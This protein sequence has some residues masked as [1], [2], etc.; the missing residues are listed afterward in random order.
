MKCDLL[1]KGGTVVDPAN[2]LHGTMDVAVGEGRIVAIASQLPHAAAGRVV[3]VRGSIVTAGLVDLHTHCYWGATYWGIDPDPVAARTGVTTWVDAGSAGAFN[4]PGFRR[5]VFEASTA[6]TFAFLN[7]STIGL[8]APT[9]ELANLAYCDVV[10]GATIVEANRDCI[11]GIKV[12]VDRWTTGEAG[13][14]GLRRART[15]A[16]Q[17]GLP[18]MVHIGTAPP[19]LQEISAFLRTGDILT[20]CFTGQ[21]NRLVDAAGAALSAALRLRERGVLLDTGHGS[22]SFSFGSAEAL[23][24]AGI[25]PDV[26]SSDMHQL[27][28]IGHMRDLPTTL[29]KFLALGMRLDEVIAC[30]TIRPAMAIGRDDLGTLGVGARAD[31]AVF[32]IEEGSFEFY[33][34]TSAER[35][36]SVRLVNTA[37]FVGGHEF[38]QLQEPAPAPWAVRDLGSTQPGLRGP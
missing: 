35:R 37:T 26:I 5:Y 18:L 7:I 19:T 4:F 16:D 27:S 33:D 1:L 23:L 31:I 14:E 28:R 6:R 10:E 9:H 34:T 2:A 13:I 20:H 32:D 21:D 15:L 30:A 38:P 12:R 22:G 17:V 29:S 3:D 11:R 25:T 8:V 36:G 24:G